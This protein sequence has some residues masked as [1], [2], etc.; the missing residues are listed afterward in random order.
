[1][2]VRVVRLEQGHRLEDVDAADDAANAFLGH[3]GTRGY[4]PA[5]VRAYAYDL[6]NF[7]T[8]IEER[9]WPW[10]RWSRRICST[11]STGRASS[12][13]VRPGRSWRWR[14]RARRPPR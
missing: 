5:T 10:A 14:G 6:A 7:L 2:G 8:F 12:V 4:S 13:A 3:L 11:I 1:M 9:D